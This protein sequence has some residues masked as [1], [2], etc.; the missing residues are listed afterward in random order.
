MS[1]KIEQFYICPWEPIR[2][3]QVQFCGKGIL[4][5]NYWCSPPELLEIL[6][7][8]DAKLIAVLSRAKIGPLYLS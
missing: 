1:A 8:L 3:H 2:P 7:L 5:P 6:S 4:I